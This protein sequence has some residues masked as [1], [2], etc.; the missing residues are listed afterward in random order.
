MKS[1]V[2]YIPTFYSNLTGNIK[3]LS[4]TGYGAFCYI[5]K[6]R[7]GYFSS[8]GGKHFRK[9]KNALLDTQKGILGKYK[10]K[11]CTVYK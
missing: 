4:Y 5:T 3:M 10:I 9:F 1:H 6:R 2:K 11:P 7:Y 8:Y